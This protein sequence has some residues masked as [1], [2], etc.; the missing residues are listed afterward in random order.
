MSYRKRKKQLAAALS[1]CAVLLA[2]SFAYAPMPVANAGL[3]S[4]GDVVGALLGGAAYSA[5]L[6]KQIKYY[7]NTEEGRQE[8]LQQIK[9]QYGVNED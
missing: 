3:F 1:A 9:D 5:Q 7:N 2:G 8:L 4:T 6:N